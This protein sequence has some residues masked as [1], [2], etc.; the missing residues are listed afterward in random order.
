MW[1]TSPDP[2]SQTLLKQTFSEKYIVVQESEITMGSLLI[3]TVTEI[4]WDVRVTAIQEEACRLEILTL[5]NVLLETNNPNM[6]EVSALNNAFKKMYSELDVTLSKKGEVL[7]VNNRATIQRKWGQIKAEMQ[8]IQ[9]RHQS[10]DGIIALNDELFASTQKVD[11]AVK[12]NEFFDLYF[13]KLYG[14]R[15]P[16][17]VSA[18]KKSLFMQ[19]DV[20][21]RYRLTRPPVTGQQ[22]S[23]SLHGIAQQI[24]DTRW[25]KQA[26][27]QFPMADA[28]TLRPQLTEEGNYLIEH[29]SGRLLKASLNRQETAHPQLLKASM[30]YTITADSYAKAE[31]DKKPNK[32]PVATPSNGGFSLLMDN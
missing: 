31:R 3:K 25:L 17:E 11:E 24:T 18:K 16:A 23:V 27:G 19:A 13:H 29:A 1:N 15:L 32:P 5:D 9:T 28:A 8:A 10:L 4:R 26:Y 14:T 22:A 7:Q 20:A 6:R 2:E 12:N 30:K 21:W